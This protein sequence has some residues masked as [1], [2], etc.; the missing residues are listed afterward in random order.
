M[1]RQLGCSGINENR[2]GDGIE[3]DGWQIYSLACIGIVG[4]FTGGR[5]W[6]DGNRLEGERSEKIWD[7]GCEAG[8]QESIK[9]FVQSDVKYPRFFVHLFKP[10][11]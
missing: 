6:G 4:Y 5:V 7:L 11:A 2:F 8:V 1:D 3:G 10:S 9:N